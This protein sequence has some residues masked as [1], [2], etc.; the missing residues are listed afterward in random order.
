V[1]IIVSRLGLQGRYQV[2]LVGLQ[3]GQQIGCQFSFRAVDRQSIA[4]GLQVDP[5]GRAFRQQDENRVLGIQ[6]IDSK[7]GPRHITN[8]LRF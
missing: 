8:L 4:A 2:G 7:K 3:P 1:G 5:S 6:G